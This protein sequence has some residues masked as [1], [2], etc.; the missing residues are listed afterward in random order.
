MFK[1]NQL[2]KVFFSLVAV[3]TLIFAGLSGVQADDAAPPMF[4][5]AGAGFD[6]GG[7]GGEFALQARSLSVNL[8]MLF[9]AE[10]RQLS[11]ENLPLITLNLFPD[12]IYTGVVSEAWHDGWGSYWQGKLSG[13]AGGYFYLTVVDGVF[14]AHIASP[15]GVYEVS[16]VS[17]D[18][19]KVV[20][21][22]QSKFIDH[23]PSAKFDPPGNI[24]PEGSLGST[25]DTGDVIDIMVAYTD[26]ARAAAGGT[27]AIKATILTALNETNTSYASSG[28]TTR[29]RLVHVQEYSYV[30]SG[31]L[32]TDLDRLTSTG[33][34]YFSTIHSLRNIYGADM[35]GL[36]VENGGMYCGL[37]NA[38]MATATNAFQVT[39]RGCA[40]GYYSFG[41]EFGH[42]QGARHDVYVDNSTTPFYHGHGFV[43]RGT[44]T[45][46]RWRTI[47]AYNNYC[48]DI[49]YNCTRLQY[50]SNPTNTWLG[51]AMGSAKAKNYLVLNSTDYTVA[52]FRTTVIGSDFVS[53]FNSSADGWAPIYGVWTIGGNIVYQSTG[54]ANLNASAKHTGRYGD[55]VYKVIMKRTG[56]CGGC[57]NH[58]YIRG[59]PSP[60][61]VKKD[62]AKSYKFAYNNNGQ[63]AVMRVNGT[64]VTML[65][66]WTSST[67][68]VVNGWN[69][70][71]VIAVDAS[72]K[73]YINGTMVWSGT[74][75]AY[76][77]G[78]VGFGFYRNAYSATFQVNQAEL[79]T[80]A[81]AD[82]QP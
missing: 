5:Q 59:V 48:S 80:A 43:H 74:D 25:G 56:T 53:T 61:D 7:L 1:R 64:T 47:M 54:A 26:D 8:G 37:A 20:Q 66:P 44:T 2:L 45:S 73:F 33:D 6:A 31:D 78:D 58:I 55:L 28:I 3:G 57:S 11:K 17:G 12:A 14:M 22:D 65:K 75:T 41:H 60:L 24:I 18:I 71:K 79:S 50:W 34:T 23:D 10:G 29:L 16:L 46:T 35:V 52:N 76:R 19:Y 4:G 81:T 21:I 32:F 40:T 51:A 38:I 82:L 72:L 36:I 62:W 27:P 77:V 70:L 68:I 15:L 49:G 67:A 42:L 30:E 13:V 69:T 63:F 39:D 9:D